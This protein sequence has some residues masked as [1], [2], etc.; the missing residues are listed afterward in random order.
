MRISQHGIIPPR[1]AVRS[2]K[3]ATVALEYKFVAD[4]GGI[5]EGHSLDG[6]IWSVITPQGARK[7]VL[8]AEDTGMILDE[9][10][11]RTTW[12]EGEREYRYWGRGVNWI[13]YSNEAVTHDGTT[14]E[15]HPLMYE[16]PLDEYRYT[17]MEGDAV[18]G[19]TEIFDQFIMYF[20]W[21]QTPEHPFPWRPADFS[22][23]PCLRF[24]K[25]KDGKL[26]FG[27]WLLKLGEGEPVWNPL[28]PRAYL[29]A[30]EV[31]SYRYP[32]V[33]GDLMV[34]ENSFQVQEAEMSII[35]GK[36]YA[37]AFRWMGR[38]YLFPRDFLPDGSCA[39]MYYL[40]VTN[41]SGVNGSGNMETTI[42]TE[43]GRGVIAEEG[44]AFRGGAERIDDGPWRT[45][46]GASVVFGSSQTDLEDG[47][48]SAAVGGKII[49]TGESSVSEIREG[50]EYLQ[51]TM[52]GAAK[53]WMHPGNA[54]GGKIAGHIVGPSRDLTVFTDAGKYNRL[55]A[56]ITRGGTVLP[57]QVGDYAVLD[58]Y[59]STGGKLFRSRIVRED[60]VTWDLDPD[61]SEIIK[62][63]VK[64]STIESETGI[65]WD[66][67]D[68]PLLFKSYRT[69]LPIG[70][71]DF[72]P[73]D[74]S[75]IEMKWITA[76]GGII[77]DTFTL[78]SLAPNQFIRFPMYSGFDIYAVLYEDGSQV[79][80]ANIP[81]PSACSGMWKRNFAS[82]DY[83][84]ADTVGIHCNFQ[85]TQAMDFVHAPAAVIKDGSLTGGRVGFVVFFHA[86]TGEIF[87][88]MDDSFIPMV[89]D[90]EAYAPTPADPSP[91]LYIP[92]GAT[93]M[94][95]YGSD[96]FV[97]AF[98][99][100]RYRKNVAAIINWSGRNADPSGNKQWTANRMILIRMELD[101]DELDLAAIAMNCR[102]NRS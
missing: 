69:G 88:L 36:L 59:C 63:P 40:L 49:R 44:I 15:R 62:A 101:T 56:P 12:Y 50:G 17:E 79:G 11:V 90:L 7:A 47:I 67:A 52:E 14:L 35:N 34:H 91:P 70:Y 41:S 64:I 4:L 54:G 60:D 99:K 97:D 98:G 8:I 77:N 3:P 27:R 10:A 66:M 55:V 94:K 75:A 82:W 95:E 100:T 85:Y 21:V 24:M 87:Q 23:P 68:A 46:D 42:G 74:P 43:L 39:S 76:D 89:E 13:L 51:A 6:R 5:P 71:Y 9:M 33:S 31:M 72:L 61:W 83:K 38:A 78:P 1:E 30:G 57:R 26:F 80:A 73:T 2:A 86:T 65:Q 58:S 48:V 18:A 25:A 16:H 45:S 22:P 37:S 102:V 81:L 29:A 93:W 32:Q 53:Y 19:R 84:A 20:D 96:P 28:A 92:N